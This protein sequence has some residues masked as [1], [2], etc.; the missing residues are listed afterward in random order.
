MLDYYM[1]VSF[2]KIR[3]LFLN[4]VIQFAGGQEN[5]VTM[6]DLRDKI[7]TEARGQEVGERI[8]VS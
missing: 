8:N 3:D 7:W 1:I 2:S 4:K 5:I 6:E